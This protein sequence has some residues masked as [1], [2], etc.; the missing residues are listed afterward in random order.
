M[1]QQAIECSTGKHHVIATDQI[2]WRYEG[3]GHYWLNN[4]QRSLDLGCVASLCELA[5]AVNEC[6]RA[7]SGDESWA[8][9]TAARAI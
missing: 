3:P 9:W 7:G 2:G 4:G 8:G 1:A 5:T 6:V